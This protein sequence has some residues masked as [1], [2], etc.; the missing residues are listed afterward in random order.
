MSK[1]LLQTSSDINQLISLYQQNYSFDQLRDIYKCGLLKI[2]KI[3]NDNNILIRNRKE[4]INQKIGKQNKLPVDEIIKLYTI[5]NL[6]TTEIGKRYNCDH[7]TISRILWKNNIKPHKKKLK[8]NQSIKK[9]IILTNEQIQNIINDYNKNELSCIEIRQK[10]NCSKRNFQK[11]TKNIP[12]RTKEASTLI[13]WNKLKKTLN[14][15]KKYILPSGKI[16]YLQGYEPQFLDYIFQNNILKETEINYHPQSI[17]YI[18]YDNKSHLYMPDFYIPKWNLIVE[19]KST[20]VLNYFDKDCIFKK[21][22]CINQHYNYL[23][24][25]DNNFS[26]FNDSYV[27]PA[28]FVPTAGAAVDC[29]AGACVAAGV[30]VGNP[31][32]CC[33]SAPAGAGPNSGGV[34]VP[35]AP[36][37]G[38]P[39]PPAPI[40]AV[41]AFIA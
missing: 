9:R 30:C 34:S 31:S 15:P 36:P 23:L 35:S 6:S 1:H 25:L 24:L 29:V 14:C 19:I 12:H 18:G 16:V 27:L 7:I 3:L 13:S 10:Y 40:S 11:I 20:F 28:G 39:P 2:R 38:I 8:I 41:A 17:K 21:N 33:S 26:E 22:A 4:T 32:G 37:A 5:Q